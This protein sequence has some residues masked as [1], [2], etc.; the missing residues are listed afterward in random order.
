[1]AKSSLTAGH[2]SGNKEIQ[3]IATLSSSIA[4]ELKNYL[5]AINICAELSEMQLNKIM[6]TVRSADYLIGNLLLQ[7]N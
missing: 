7:I 5:A 4:H 1:M 2:L 3:T 6:K